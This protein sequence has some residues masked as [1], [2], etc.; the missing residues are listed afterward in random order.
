MPVIKSECS[1]CLS[2]DNLVTHENGSV[3]CYTP[4]CESNKNRSKENLE[5]S[6]YI[7]SI[8]MNK[9]LI[10]GTF[11]AIPSRRI[12]Q[13]TCEFFNY[14]VGIDKN[15]RS[16]Q[17]AN[18]IE[19]Q[20]CRTADKQFFW[21]GGTSKVGL[22]GK[23][24]WSSGKN[25]IIT[26][27]EIDALSIAE[28]Q[29]CKWPVVSLPNGAQSARKTL[30]GELN[31]LLGFESIILCFDSDVAGK[32][33]VETCV[34]LF[35]PGRLKIASLSE[36]DANDCLVKGKFDELIR[37]VFN[38][39]EYRPDGIIWG[40]EIELNALFNK[41]PRGLTL[42]Y[43]ILDDAIRG[44]K[45]GRIYTIYA[46]TGN[47]KST[48]MREIALHITQRHKDTRIANIFLEESL[49]FT[50]LSYI[51]M[52]NNIPAY[53]IEEN[54]SL[55]SQ[56]QKL[57]GKELISD[58]GFY[59]HFGSLDSKHLFNLLDYLVLAKNV[60]L[61]MLDHIS[62][63][64]SGMK[65]ESGE[66]E[67]RDIDMLVTNLR[68]FC[69]RTKAI[70][71]CATQLKRKEKS[72]SQGAEITESDA[73]GSG[74]IEHIS[75]VVFSLNVKQDSDNPYDAQIK[76]IKNRITGFKGNADLITYNP[77]TGRYLP[78]KVDISSEAMY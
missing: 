32:T 39:Q 28:A 56:E 26:E 37:I 63:L 62:L 68:S 60:K 10:Q 8:D 48:S 69:E 44:L 25:I 70:V 18:Y 4:N 34:D 36:K 49:G 78:K 51:A 19:S 46:G 50:A 53:K 7:C 20:K 38:A 24:K 74:A 21:L 76:I 64:V 59:R 66:G 42:P 47:G 1:F 72:Y 33:A 22:F 67:R 77:E 41:Q 16:V 13:R 57:K 40:N 17:I 71:V 52:D 9:D 27:G 12:S 43:P 65:S 58:M 11:S 55:L 2:S 15:G 29:D 14:Q 5:Q 3:W 31:W 73:R 54:P 35:P 45:D 23:Q 75:D 61:I 6:R 30:E